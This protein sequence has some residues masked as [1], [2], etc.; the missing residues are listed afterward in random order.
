LGHRTQRL[1]EARVGLLFRAP[2]FVRLWRGRP[3][4]VKAKFPQFK[5][6][7]SYGELMGL[8]KRAMG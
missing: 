8:V 3:D 2:A 4:N 5:A 6:V 1:T 7:E